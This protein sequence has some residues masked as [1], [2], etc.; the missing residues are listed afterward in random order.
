MTTANIITMDEP[1]PDEATA[2]IRKL[3]DD[4]LANEIRKLERQAVT[5]SK[6]IHAVQGEIAKL[7]RRRDLL[8][9]EQVRRLTLRKST[10]VVK[11]NGNG[12]RD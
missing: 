3:E 2:L 4:A 12:A 1:Q 5:R 7:D 11:E 8:L 10:A 9:D 6:K